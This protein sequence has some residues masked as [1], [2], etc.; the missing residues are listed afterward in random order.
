MAGGVVA[1]RLSKAGHNVTLVEK[2]DI[3]SPYE[4]E[5]E[6]WEYDSPK[7]A[8]TRGIGIGGT[9]NY[10]H[11]GLTTLDKV[12]IDDI[13]QVFGTKKM[14]IGYEELTTYY[15]KAVEYIKSGNHYSIND[16]KVA[17][18][19]SANDFQINS[20]LFSY[21]G[22]IYPRNAFSTRPQLLQAVN[23]GRIN[24]IRNLEAQRIEFSHD[25]HASVLVGYDT[26][27][28]QHK[29]ISADIF[30][31]CAGGLG[32]PKLLLN[33]TNNNATLA[34]LPV[35]KYLIDHPTG[36]VF[37]AKLRKRMNLGNVFGQNNN[38]Y[39]VQY[40]FTLRPDKLAIADYRNHIVY[41]RPAITMKDPLQYDVLKRKLVGYKGKRLA[42]SDIAYLF[43]HSDLLYEALNFKYGLF[44][45]TRYV[46]GL[47][48]LDQ[49]PNER[50]GISLTDNNKYSIKWGISEIDASSANKFLKT[51]LDGHKDM[52]ENYVLYPDLRKRLETAG[53]HSGTC[54]MSS[55]PSTGV[56]DQNLKV[57]GVNN[58]YLVDASVLGHAGHAN[59][60][61]TIIA[62]ALKC[63][64][65]IQASI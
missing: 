40:G 64:E 18:D 44:P 65:S 45:V 52:F 38:G 54:R 62:L 47:T 57:F 21:K 14:P 16:I 11:S 26:V 37:K 13:S 23:S 28:K 50:D 35:G 12:D 60:G 22:L 59:T 5:N 56:V 20:E 49:I 30:I 51:F 58:L 55:D 43:R 41:M 34:A 32:S 42:L 36:F 8:F 9:S 24:I 61:L 19:N 2:G 10:W 15:E 53:H 25:N 3:P 4:P 7:A 31:L 39:R 1:T 48:F 63:A 46:S 33:S 27:A 6:L 29:K 17:P